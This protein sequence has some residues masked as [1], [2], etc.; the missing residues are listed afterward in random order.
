[1]ILVVAGH[2]VFEATAGLNLEFSSKL[3]VA[4]V[5]KCSESVFLIL[6]G[7]SDSRSTAQV[8][9]GVA[10]LFAFSACTGCKSRVNTL[11]NQV[12]GSLRGR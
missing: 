6:R 3:R 12:A 9:T 7:S 8:Q 10:I 11:Q 1:M 2:W 4:S 5:R